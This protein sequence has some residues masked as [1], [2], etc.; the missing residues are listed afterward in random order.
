M[1]FR[2]FLFFI[3]FGGIILAVSLAGGF[4]KNAKKQNFFQLT[5]A[6]NVGDFYSSFFLS[7]FKSAEGKLLLFSERK[8][9]S[10][11]ESVEV[12]GLKSEAASAGEY[13]L[14]LVNSLNNL[15]AE[16]ISFMTDDFELN[17]YAEL[18]K[19]PLIFIF[20]ELEL[21]LKSG[22]NERINVA[23]KALAFKKKI[24]DLTYNKAKNIAVKSSLA[25]SQRSFLRW[26]K[27]NSE[28]IGGL[29][30]KPLNYRDFLIKKNYYQRTFERNKEIISK[31][32]A[33]HSAKTTH[34]FF[35][36]DLKQSFLAL[37]SKIYAAAK[38]F[39][40]GGM[41]LKVAYSC[42]AG[43][44]VTIELAPAGK[45]V[46]YLPYFFEAANPFLYNNVTPGSHILGWAIALP[47][48]CNYYPTSMSSP[49][50]LLPFYG[51]SPK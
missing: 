49:P 9:S 13:A 12:G 25:S 44:Y 8:N 33:V 30:E 41:I 15:T 31:L 10:L 27:Y 2:K 1:I 50:L 26:L 24:F 7:V 38:P 22:D 47:F 16:E 4:L 17:D 6:K 5:N 14:Q 36:S 20:N 18:K 35:A 39:P 34:S 11:K 43:Q 21:A 29:V 28:F 45:M 51:T 23:K 40:Y 42:E 37:I 46:G 48:I 3:I 19:K 32:F